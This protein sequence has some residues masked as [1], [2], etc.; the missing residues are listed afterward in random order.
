MPRRDVWRRRGWRLRLDWRLKAIARWRFKHMAGESSF[1]VTSPQERTREQ[2]HAEASTRPPT[3]NTAVQFERSHGVSV[4][5]ALHVGVCSAAP[6]VEQLHRMRG[7]MHIAASSGG[8]CCSSMTSFKNEATSTLQYLNTRWLNSAFDMD[9]RAGRSL[10]VTV[11]GLSDGGKQAAIRPSKVRVGVIPE[12]PASHR[13]SHVR[14][15]AVLE[16]PGQSSGFSSQA[17]GFTSVTSQPL[18]AHAAHTKEPAASPARARASP[19][20]L[21]RGR[22]ARIVWRMD[23][24]GPRRRRVSR[25]KST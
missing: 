8:R 13:Q 12:K 5:G 15:V 1:G 9:S 21:G 6:A 2:E 16:E 25:M 22:F 10:S 18:I 24:G 23:T 7:P 3:R 20:R 19:S 4:H 17:E 14:S 11:I